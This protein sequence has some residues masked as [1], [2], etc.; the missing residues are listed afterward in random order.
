MPIQRSLRASSEVKPGGSIL[1]R[2]AANCYSAPRR[3]PFQL[4]LLLLALLLNGCDALP[5]RPRLPEL[6][7]LQPQGE[8]D[9]AAPPLHIFLPEEGDVTEALRGRVVAWAAASELQ[10]NLTTSDDYYQE[11]G[12]RLAG[13]DLPD[14]VLV[15]GFLF[16][17]L[18]S[19]GLLAPAEEGFLDPAD[20]PPRLAAAFTWPSEGAAALRYCLP[21]EVR[22]LALVYD[23]EGLAAAGHPPPTSWD[24]L[25]AVA[26]GQ[27]DVDR[28]R[29]GFIEAPDLSRWL[30]LLYGAGGTIIDGSGG[31]A[32]ESPAAGAAMDW[33]IRI[34]RDNFAGHAGESNNEWAGEVLA[35]GK[36]GLT[37]EGNWIAPYF[38][39]EFPGFQYGV[40]PLPSGP[41]G[42][43]TSVAY[44]SCYAVPSGSSRREDAFELAAILSG[45]DVVGSLPNDGGW[46]PALNGMREEWKRKFPRLSPFADA[47]PTAAVWQLP[48]GFD[49]F[50]RSF[51]RGMVQLF[52]ANV[53][54]ADFFAELQE[55][56]ETL[57][58]TAG[59][60]QPEPAA[61]Q[62]S[63]P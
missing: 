16:P 54:A 60:A 31:M 42:L 15:T 20:L 25:R 38:E 30:P 29:F 6:P 52:A 26:I 59:E 33:Y 58:E 49:T 21:R 11:L 5:S 56:G 22:T 34:F 48:P 57:L 61:E 28:N 41:A 24:S 53:E 12:G 19:G 36:G 10:V 1:W 63:S 27:T 43:N 50:L 9:A 7:F 4:W 40:A 35:K 8:S 46:M 37:I 3:L 39:A 14:L 51:N 17:E 13:E 55:L 44:T 23:S 18:A 32:L 62:D 45:P 2:C 47:V